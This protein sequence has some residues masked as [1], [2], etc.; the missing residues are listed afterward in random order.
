MHRIVLQGRQLNSLKDTCLECKKPCNTITTL[1]RDSVL[2]RRGVLKDQYHPFC[3]PMKSLWGWSQLRMTMPNEMSTVIPFWTAVTCEHP[4]TAE[5][6]QTGLSPRAC[7]SSG[8]VQRRGWRL[9]WWFA[10]NMAAVYGR[11]V[12]KVLA[13]LLPAALFWLRGWMPRVSQLSAE[14]IR[15]QVWLWHCR[16]WDNGGERERRDNSTVRKEVRT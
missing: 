15:K 8:V 16:G 12:Y 6:T 10:T 13:E 9:W 7:Y 5:L 11:S 1:E 3:C 14:V 2:F 4:R